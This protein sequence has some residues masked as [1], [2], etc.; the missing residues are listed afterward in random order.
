VVVRPASAAH[1]VVLLC[2]GGLAAVNAETGKLLFQH[3][4]AASLQGYSAQSLFVGMGV[5]STAPQQP[6][7]PLVIASTDRGVFACAAATGRKVWEYVVPNIADGE[8]VVAVTVQWD[9]QFVIVA[10]NGGGS[11]SN[12]GSGS[13]GGVA[14]S[15]SVKKQN[16]ARLLHKLRASSNSAAASSSTLLVIYLETG[17][18]EPGAV[19]TTPPC[20]PGDLTLSTVPDTPAEMLPAILVACSSEQQQPAVSSQ[21]ISYAIYVRQIRVTSFDT[22]WQIVFRNRTLTNSNGYYCANCASPLVFAPSATSA[23]TLQLLASELRFS[24]LNNSLELSSMSL[25]DGTTS[26]TTVFET[27]SVSQDAGAC[28][29]AVVAG[30]VAVLICSNSQVYGVRI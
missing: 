29:I 9:S 15:H 1:A 25:E 27:A 2:G 5:D 3:A 23:S 19:M 14:Q 30:S 4:N 24:N 11:S 18:P 13:S 20:A 21:A 26:W 28:Q 8:R 6:L 10:V 22:K 7:I 16:N 12:S 17:K